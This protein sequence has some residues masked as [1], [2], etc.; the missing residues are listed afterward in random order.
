MNKPTLAVALIVKNEARHLDEC[1]Q[2]VH[3]WVDEIVVLDSGSHDETEQVARRYTEKFYVNSK[4]PGF[5]PQRQLA[6]SYVQ[7]DYV[8]WLDADERVTPELKQSI[9]QAVAANKPDTLYQFARLSWV[10]GRFIRHSGWYPDRVLRLYPTQLTRYNDALVHEKVHV[11]PSMKVETLAGDAIHYTY[12]DVH[13]YLVKS[14]GYAKAW[15][16]QRQ[17]K[18][19]KT[20]LSQGIVHAVGCFLKMYLLKRGFLD[21]K[22]GFLIALLSVH[23]TFVKYADLWARDNDEHYKR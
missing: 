19:K 18:G 6:Q 20:T 17:A 2:T 9:L 15:A 23:S 1:L 12:N 22:Q 7:S 4:W 14:A 3:D 8:L 10:F 11:E 16:D 13:H 5:G 21:G